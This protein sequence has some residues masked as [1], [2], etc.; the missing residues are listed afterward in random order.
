MKQFIVKMSYI[1]IYMFSGVQFASL[2]LMFAA[3]V[4][5]QL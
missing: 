1:I 2:I 5:T 4:I 3:V